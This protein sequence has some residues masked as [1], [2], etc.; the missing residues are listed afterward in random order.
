[1]PLITYPR[2]FDV[3]RSIIS[4]KHEIFSIVVK[5]AAQQNVT[6]QTR[7][8][9]RVSRYDCI[10]NTKN[11]TQAI[12]SGIFLLYVILPISYLRAFSIV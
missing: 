9:I 1:M 6:E 11:S 4:L 2:V 3:Y 5:I 8:A 10:L 7:N 12:L